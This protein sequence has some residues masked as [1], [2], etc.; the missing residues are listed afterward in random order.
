MLSQPERHVYSLPKFGFF[1]FCY[2]GIYS[3]VT[4]HVGGAG[5][6]YPSL[7]Q[8]VLPRILYAAAPPGN[9]AWENRKQCLKVSAF[10][11]LVE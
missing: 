8:A 2:N 1:F 4:N 7:I 5:D 3:T 6:V 10:D 11:G 9:S